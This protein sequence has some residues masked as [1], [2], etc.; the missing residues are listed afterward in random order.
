MRQFSEGRI[1]FNEIG[2]LISLPQD[3]TVQE[4]ELAEKNLT[5]QGMHI[6]ASR[7]TCI[8]VDIKM[9]NSGVNFI[10]PPCIVSRKI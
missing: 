9:L 1:L 2:D 5:E 7:L 4:I 8:L 3:V 6:M 10:V